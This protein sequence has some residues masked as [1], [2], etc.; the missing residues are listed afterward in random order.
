MIKK[1]R[2]NVLE[3]FIYSLNYILI[4]YALSNISMVLRANPAF[5]LFFASEIWIMGLYVSKVREISG[6]KILSWIMLVVCFALHICMVYFIGLV[7]GDIIPFK[8]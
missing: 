2:S 1:K 6:N 5:I 3:I 8:G 7:E 4:S